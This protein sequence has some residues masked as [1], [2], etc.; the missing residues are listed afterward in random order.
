MLGSEHHSFGGNS[1]AL[2]HAQTN[3]D[4]EE[5]QNQMLLDVLSSTLAHFWGNSCAMSVA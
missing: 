3:F 4:C 1:L 2:S 5:L